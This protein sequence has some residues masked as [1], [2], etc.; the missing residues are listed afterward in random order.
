MVAVPP[1][2]DDLSAGVAPALNPLKSRAFISA[3]VEVGLTEVV[4]LIEDPMAAPDHPA[5]AANGSAQAA[6]PS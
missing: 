1:P 3:T 2:D 6:D 4:G 5:W